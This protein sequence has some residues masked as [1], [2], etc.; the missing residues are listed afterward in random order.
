M[1]RHF[2][3]PSIEFDIPIYGGRAYLYRTDREYHQACAYLGHPVRNPDPM[4]GRFLHCFNRAGNSVYLVGWFNDDWTVLVHE[5][6][7][8][9]LAILDY[10]GIQPGEGRGE[11]YCYLLQSLLLLLQPI[12]F[13]PSVP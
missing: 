3:K 5:A 8:C 10:C 11:P 13:V 9:A 1:P 6:A 4:C 2:P 12:P 7:H